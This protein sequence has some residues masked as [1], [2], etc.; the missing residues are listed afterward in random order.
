LSAAL[1]FAGMRVIDITRVLASPYTTYQLGLLGAE[2][3][4]VEDPSVGGDTSRNRVGDD[5]ELAK[6]GMATNFISLNGNKKSI[7]LDLRKPEGQA[8]LRK[9]ASESDILVE[10]LRTGSMDGFGVGYED[11]HKINPRLIFCSITGYGATG[12]KKSHPAYDPVIQAACGMMSITGSAESAPLKGGA[13]VIDYAAG[14]AGAFA[15]SAAV[16]QRA[17]TG[18]GQYIDISMLEVA[19]SLMGTSVTEILTSGSAPRPWGN[20][21]GPYI[22]LNRA[23]GTADAMLWIAASEPHQLK[24]FWTVLDRW[25]IP[26]DARFATV[27]DRRTNWIALGEEVERTLKTRSAQEWEDLFNDAGVPAMRVRSIPEAL[28]HPQVTERNF[29]HTFNDVPGVGRATVPLLPFNMS[30]APARMHAPP[31]TLGQHN[32]EVLAGLGY[33][34]AEIAAFKTHGAI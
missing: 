28:A 15:I 24:N 16:I 9:L 7:T 17:Q 33:S 23:F 19:F 22:P 3:I 12:P 34:V 21:F 29:L 25:D 2:V 14:L 13:P 27:M 18:L 5:P 1:P 6:L 8:I 11:L 4:K 26:A 10:N 32:D 31:P 30:A 20:S